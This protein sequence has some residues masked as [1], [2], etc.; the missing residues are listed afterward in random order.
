MVE[1]IKVSHRKNDA[2]NIFLAF[3]CTTETLCLIGNNEEI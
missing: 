2:R 3:S 1:V